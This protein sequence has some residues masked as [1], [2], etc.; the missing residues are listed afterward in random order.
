MIETGRQ[1]FDR[2]YGTEKGSKYTLLPSDKSLGYCQPTLRVEIL[3][4]SVAF[5]PKDVGNDNAYRPA[6]IIRRQL[7]LFYR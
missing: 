1:R 2:P 6:A 7:M 4:V 5:K 3:A